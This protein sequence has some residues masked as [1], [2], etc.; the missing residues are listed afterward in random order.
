ME[1]KIK[2]KISFIKPQLATLTKKYFSS[3]DWLYEDKLDGIRC[4]AVKK[5]G[6]VKLYS[7][8]K[9]ILNK[10]FP[11][12]VKTLEKQKQKNFIL[13]GEIVAFDKNKTSFSKLQQVKKE[14]I[15]T[16]YYVF[17]LLFFN[18]QNFLKE[19][20]LTRKKKLKKSF[21]FT[22]N[23]RYT[24]HILK[25]GIKLFKKNCREK[26]E[27]IIAK[28]ITSI[29]Q[30]KRTSYWL[31]FKCSNRQEFIIIGYT[32]PQKTRVGFGA[33]LIG[34]YEKGKIK[35]AG[36]VGTGFDQKFLKEFSEK[37]KKIKTSK[38]CTLDKIPLKNINF[39]RPKYIA[40]IK[41]S[42][43]TKDGKLRHPS[44][45]GLRYDKPIKK[46]IKES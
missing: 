39:V 33:I 20:L 9:N 34:Y 46:V 31:K 21:N 22:N 28:K 25:E 3:S 11:L 2:S 19:D 44:F 12:I 14:K 13:D 43:F 4:I 6:V 5:N 30:S 27:G 37:L 24:K 18:D 1:K 42:H 45:L 38:S 8:N 41:F 7:R 17:D 40:E 23:F 15:P 10:T 36:K 35:Y 26:K 29:Y 16:F 32:L